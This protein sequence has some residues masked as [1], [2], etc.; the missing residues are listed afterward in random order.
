[1]PRVFSSSTLALS[2]AFAGLLLAGGATVAEAQR[3]FRGGN[4]SFQGSSGGPNIEYDGRF[5]M[6]RMWYDWHDGWC[7]D[8]PDME[9]NFVLILKEITVIRPHMNRSN[10]LRFDDTEI[11]KFPMVYVSEPGFWQPSAEDLRGMRDYMLKGGLVFFDDFMRQEW[12]NFEVHFKR[13]FPD[14]IFYR[15]EN[16]HPIFDSFY[17][18]QNLA[19]PYPNTGGGNLTAEFYAVYKD[20]DPNRPMMA[21]ISYNSDLGDY[22]EWSGTGRNPIN[23]ANEAYKFAVNFVIYGMTR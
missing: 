13:A 3:G 2:A 8:Y 23:L 5:I 9:R 7:Y 4:C 10:V 6:V 15:L 20:N 16:T 11:F 12:Y 22:M 21:I 14:A 19:I 17:R 1:M 18:I